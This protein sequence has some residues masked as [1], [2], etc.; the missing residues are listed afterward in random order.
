[1]D[2]ECRR[3]TTTPGGEEYVRWSGM[4]VWHHTGSLSSG[5]QSR[6]LGSE[7]QDHMD[8]VVASDPVP[9]AP[10]ANLVISK[11]VRCAAALWAGVAGAVKWYSQSV[12]QAAA[13]LLILQMETQGNP[14]SQSSACGSAVEWA[15]AREQVETDERRRRYTASSMATER[16]F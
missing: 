16:E 11:G 10:T 8:G 1:M 2:I 4:G 6:R 13:E 12:L 5:C 14:F 9:I 7:K 15:R 3:T